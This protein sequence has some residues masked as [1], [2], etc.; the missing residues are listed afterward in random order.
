MR[1]GK[2][3]RQKA[4]SVPAVNPLVE[5]HKLGQSPW[6]D[7]IHRALLSSGRL[8]RLIAAGE[9]TG[10]TSNPTI[11]EQAIASTRDYDAEL[12]ALDAI[13]CSKI[14]GFEVSPVTSPAAIRR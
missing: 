9:V 6:H 1:R 5:L 11:F 10:L 13:A 8:A 7:N 3:A 2:M 12:P 14:V 4:T